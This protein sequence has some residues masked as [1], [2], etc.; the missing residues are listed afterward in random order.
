M[1]D[2]P[3]R[4]SAV[5]R[6]RDEFARKSAQ[7]IAW[8][9]RI[10]T[11]Q[12]PVVLII[13]AWA[14]LVLPLVYFRGFNSDEGVAI[15]VARTAIHDGHWLTPHMFNERF[16]ERPTLLSWT[17]AAISLPFGNPTQLT[18][19]LP[20]V[21]A[22]LGGCLLIF[23]MLKRVASVPAALFGAA[24]FLACPL[25]LRSYVMTTADLPLAVLLFLAFVLW[26]NAFESRR[27]TIRRWI[28]IGIVLALAGLMKGPQP[29]GYFALGIGMFVLLTRSWS[30]IP[31]LMIAGLVCVAPMAAWYAA[32]FQPGDTGT[33]AAFMRLN[34]A[35]ILAGPP[36][37][38]V[39]L[40]L[41]TA[42]ASF[43]AAVVLAAHVRSN[44][45]TDHPVLIKALACYAFTCSVVVLF[46]PGGTALRYFFPVVLP[47]CVLGGIG[48]DVLATR[49]PS[50]VASMLTVTMVF[51]GYGLV[52]STIAAPLLPE[53]FRSARIDGAQIAAMVGTAPGPI[54]RTG[55]TGLNE[56][57]YVPS[58][59]IGVKFDDLRTIKGPAWFALPVDEAAQILEARNGELNV[60][61]P[62]G[63]SQEWRLLR[64]KQP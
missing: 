53:K 42:P 35:A 13:A 37:S 2:I 20:I 31:G 40:F 21:L 1:H 56:L 38:A 7:Q 62:F 33:W 10:A 50:F 32:V 49:R 47:V 57:L 58:P 60:A 41:N 44:T 55:P 43:V 14:L 3:Q 48:Y 5:I 28:V 64:L 29:I 18:A 27:L 59:V 34:P 12:N 8:W 45:V 4:S 36:H 51:L 6:F 46:W 26:W 61:M 23:G 9:S 30:Q 39:S 16:V 63:Q 54:Y 25:V 22:L 15:T 19:R 24:L 17:I 52:Y 11:N